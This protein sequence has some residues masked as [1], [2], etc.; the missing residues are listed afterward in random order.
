MTMKPV[1]V[2]K[3]LRHRPFDERRKLPVP[4]MNMID[5]ER[6]DFVTITASQVDRCIR[7]RLCSVCGKRLDYW[8]AF[9]GNEVSG[10]T[11][12]FTDP[13][14]HEACALASLRLCPMINHG[15][16]TRAKAPRVKPKDGEEFIDPKASRVRP[17]AW[18]MPITTQ[19]I[20]GI[21]C[22]IPYFVSGPY[23]RVR[24]WRNKQDGPGLIELETQ[25]VDRLLEHTLKPKEI[26]G[27]D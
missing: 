4:L 14:M 8:L 17:V 11:H 23:K 25:E 16:M 22:R 7:E 19:F 3:F 24:A 26:Q 6:W 2:P 5:D 27:N 20:V 13:P 18:F 21:N 1:D 15:N 9:I 10:A 12:T